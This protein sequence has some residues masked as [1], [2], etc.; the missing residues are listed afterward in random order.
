MSTIS[1][2]IRRTSLTALLVVILALLAACASAPEATQQAARQLEERITVVQNEIESAKAAYDQRLNGDFRDI[3]DYSGE[4]RHVGEFAQADAALAQVRMD[5]DMIVEPLI[6]GYAAE[7]QMQ[8]DTAIINAN[9]RLDDAL[10]FAN[11]PAQWGEYLLNVRNDAGGIVATATA[12][13]SALTNSN[14]ALLSQI[15]AAAQAFPQQAQ[16]TTEMSDHFAG[17]QAEAATAVNV[18]QTEAAKPRPDFPLIAEQASL[19]EHNLAAFRTEEPPAQAMLEELYVGETRTLLDIVAL[20]KVT[21]TRTSWDE[22]SCDFESCETVYEYEEKQV[23]LP[24]ADVFALFAPDAPVATG[25]GGDRLDLAQGMTPEAWG[26]LGIDPNAA[27]PS[28]DNASEFNAELE[29]TYC[30]Q[31][32]GFYDGQPSLH[33]RPDPNPETNGC[34]GLDTPADL[35]AGKFWAESD[36]LRAEDIGTDIYSKAPGDFADQATTAATPPGM[37]YVG[38]PAT[39]EWQ[40]DSGGNQFWAFYGQYAF[41]SQLIGGTTPYHYRSEYDTWDRDHRRRDSAYY[42]FYGGSPRYGAG[43]PQAAARYGSTRFVQSG[44][45]NSTVRNAGVFARSGGPGGG[46]K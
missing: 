15:Q 29:E 46:G 20:P 44:L 36:E 14:D 13:S 2:P 5:Y 23:S 6:D 34:L 45:L 33:A 40:T 18:L 8:L 31:L 16:R 11:M 21:V 7:R 19:V 37:A 43:S 32:Q 12:S 1:R 4:E 3:A 35:A 27:F 9:D 25:N 22:W 28:F 17:L 42:G 10:Q 38:N 26:E 24:A 39:G 30:H 41:F